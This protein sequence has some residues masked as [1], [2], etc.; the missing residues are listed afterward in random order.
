M[1]ARYE[2]VIKTYGYACK[3]WL[4][5]NKNDYSGIKLDNLINNVD[6]LHLYFP[7]FIY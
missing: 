2:A 7:K 4:L 1:E 3:Y 6:A 5:T